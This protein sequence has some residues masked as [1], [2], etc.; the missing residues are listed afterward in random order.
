MTKL[1]VEAVAGGALG[2][3]RGKLDAALLLPQSPVSA[4][5]R[6][7]RPGA[8]DAH[9]FA[10]SRGRTDAI[11]LN[12]PLTRVVAYRDIY[13]VECIGPSANVMQI[14]EPPWS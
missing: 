10:G 13:V 3:W 7:P 11:G 5:A 4:T 8:R 6:A 14:Y 2:V 12:P 1:I 9:D